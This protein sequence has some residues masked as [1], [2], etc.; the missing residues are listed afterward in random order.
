MGLPTM[1]LRCIIGGVPILSLCLLGVQE[2]K[3][4]AF[5]SFFS[6]TNDGTKWTDKDNWEERESIGVQGA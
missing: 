3:R 6:F 5:F 1:E 2:T 4:R